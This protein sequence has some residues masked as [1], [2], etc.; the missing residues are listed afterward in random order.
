MRVAIVH[1]WFVT[2][3]GG[4]RVAEVLAGMFPGAD[5]FTLLA[6][7]DQFPQGVSGR[8]LR[9]S[10]LQRIPNATRFHRHLLPLYPMAVEDL[11]LTSYDLVLS[12]DSGP[13]KG[14]ITRPD[15]IHVCYCHSPM[16]YLWDSYHA[17]RTPMSSLARIPFSLTAHYLRNWDYL[18]A[19]RVTHFL[20]NSHYVAGR[21]RHYYGQPS[22]VIHPPIDTLRGI[23]SPAKGE[24]YLAVGRLVGYKRT[25]IMID[26]CNRLRRRLL[27]VGEGPESKRLRA[28]A[29]PTIEFLGAVDTQQLWQTYAECRA[30]LFAADED[31]GMV[32]LEAQACG[33]PVI[34][35]GKGGSLET[36]RAW[37]EHPSRQKLEGPPT[38]IFFFEQDTRSMMNAI[39]RFE[40]TEAA[41]SPVHI[42]AFARQFDTSIFRERVGAFIREAT[43]PT[44]TSAVAQSA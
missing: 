40:A 18:A 42:Q 31:F 15:A 16:R 38:G 14:V 10:F 39:L 17:Y 20:A 1:H 19:Q 25:E 28:L 36:V 2:H 3:G 26:A 21:I 22:T 33:R 37:S 8:K 24:Y 6:D 41:F 12:S 29:G 23:L 34:A 4:E 44:G 11:D 43:A 13:V 5:L 32:P 9:T 35:Y 27:I 30:L 7:R